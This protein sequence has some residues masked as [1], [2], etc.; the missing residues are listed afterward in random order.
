MRIWMHSQ[1]FTDPTS[2]FLTPYA[3]DYG[4]GFYTP[5]TPTSTNTTIA[6]VQHNSITNTNSLA[7]T[8]N[9]TAGNCIV[10]A[11]VDEFIAGSTTPAVAD[12]LGNTYTLATD[13]TVQGGGK[14]C[15]LTLY[16]AKNILAGANTVTVTVDGNST[17]LQGLVIYEY[18]G[19]DTV[20][21]LDVTSFAH[22]ASPATTDTA[23]FTTATAGELI[24]IIAGD[25]NNSGGSVGL[26][27]DAAY[28]SITGTGAIGGSNTFAMSWLY[29]WAVQTAAGAGTATVSS[30][31]SATNFSEVYVALKPSVAMGLALVECDLTQIAAAKTDNR[32]VVCGTVWDA[33]PAQ[34]L[35][36]YSA[37]L[38][39][40]VTYTTMGQVLSRLSQTKPGFTFSP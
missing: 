19:V 13:D 37:S 11:I 26:S 33:P 21:P 24:A 2:G 8:G 32:V 5:E 28:T 10:V 40:L 36:T 16:Y 18:S 4:Q 23:S 30:A 29:Q 14:V 3:F 22:A 38:D 31:G 15:R 7:F 35:S 12:S 27:G 17:P 1:F 9:N 6:H 34:V 20:A 25:I 39:P